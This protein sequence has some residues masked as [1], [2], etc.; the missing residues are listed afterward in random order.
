MTRLARVTGRAHAAG[1][2]LHFYS[3][4]V[5]T[6]AFLGTSR[7]SDREKARALRQ[8]A[9]EGILYGPAS[10]LI[11]DLLGREEMPLWRASL[12]GAQRGGLDWLR[13]ALAVARDVSEKC[14]HENAEEQRSLFLALLCEP[15]AR[16][17]EPGALALRAEQLFAL[18]RFRD[19]RELFERAASKMPRNPHLHYRHGC[20][21]WRIPFEDPG[22]LDRKTTDELFASAERSL[23]LAH[24]LAVEEGPTWALPRRW[25]QPLVELGWIL[26][27]TGRITEALDHARDVLARIGRHTAESAFFLGEAAF[28]N[29]ELGTAL[30]A[31]A[32][33]LRLNP[34]HQLAAERAAA[35]RA[36][37]G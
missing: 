14:E 7:L 32:H 15:D 30:S 16:D 6:H 4:F 24:R 2:A 17:A 31:Y 1:A 28:A 26:L 11:R 10:F 13:F 33:C 20:A 37:K 35:A 3:Y 22:S 25:D 18:N 27:E 21:A 12:A 23:W 34:R 8:I 29:E 9:H 19:A 36:A 5:E